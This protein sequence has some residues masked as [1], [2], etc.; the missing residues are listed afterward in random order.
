[1][2]QQHRPPADGPLAKLTRRAQSLLGS[3]AGSHFDALTERARAVFA[4]AQEEA[5]HLNHNY[6]GTEHVLLGLIRQREGGA[7]KVLA[8]V[9]IDLGEVRRAVEAIVGRGERPASGELCLTP[10]TKKVLE[11]ASA[12]ARRLKHSGVG[13]EHLLLG[14]VREGEGIAANVLERFGVSFD[15]VRT[16]VV[17]LLKKDNVV[18]CRVSDPDLEAIDALIEAGICA[19]RS[20]AASWLL[21]AGVEANEPLFQRV[22]ET[23]ADIRRLRQQAQAA[24]RQLSRHGEPTPGAPPE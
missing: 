12:E 4:L 20:E 13:P 10:R 18:T 22:H 17:S 3:P 15:D 23:I 11:L 1:M 9:G 21:H 14:L 5:Q 7:A 6:L 16:Q 8:N 2:D 24:A 19:T